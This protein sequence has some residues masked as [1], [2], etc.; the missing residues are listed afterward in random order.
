MKGYVLFRQYHHERAVY[1]RLLGKAL[2]SY[3]PFPV[4]WRKSSGGLR[5][6]V[7]PLF[8]RYVFVRCCLEM[9]THRGCI[10]TLGV[11]R[12]Q[13]NGLGQV[14]VMSEEEI[15]PLRQLSDSGS[16]LQRI[17]RSYR[18]LCEGSATSPERIPA[19]PCSSQSPCFK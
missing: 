19:R 5:Q 15:R 16:P 6:A 4:V 11:V 18:A 3:M 2:Q 13:G 17:C 9:Y 7:T 10:C 14:L 1:E 8:Q 12:L